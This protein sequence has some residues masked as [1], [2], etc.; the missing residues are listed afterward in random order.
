LIPI[1]IK[2]IYNNM[3]KKIYSDAEWPEFEITFTEDDPTSGIRLVS[4]VADPAIDVKGMYFSKDEEKK[5]EFKAIKDKM[6]VVGPALIPN[7]R[8]KRK[9]DDYGNHKVFF[10]KDTIKLLVDKFN[11][12]NTGK[13]MNVL[14]T[15]TMA[16]A[17][18]SENWIVDDPYY[19][20]SKLYGYN[21]PVGSW[22]ICA[23]IE[24]EDF[25]ETSVKENNLYSF[26][27]EGLLGQKISSYQNQIYEAIDSM[28]EDDIMD[29]LKTFKKKL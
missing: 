13:S 9:S 17:F 15:D 21:L 18:I 23:K 25:W 5:Y 3:S 26:S 22:F 20:K 27:I 28:S 1:L 14:H 29:V 6:M 19:D 16:P 8:I 4:L 24:D 12:N 2:N 7:I 10:S 11:R